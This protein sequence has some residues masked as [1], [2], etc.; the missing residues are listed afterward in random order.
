MRAPER[1]RITGGAIHDPANGV[2]GETRD[3]CIEGG[4]IVD[5]LP[6]GAPTLDDMFDHGKEPTWFALSM[7]LTGATGVLIGGALVKKL[8]LGSAR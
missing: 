6:A 7:T 4:K 2:D 3:V 5:S 8:P 1:L